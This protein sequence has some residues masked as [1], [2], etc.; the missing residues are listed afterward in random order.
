[1]LGVVLVRVSIPAQTSWPRSKLGRKGFI[2]LTLPHCFSSPKEVKT[3][4]LA[5]QKA[6]ADAEAMEGCFFPGLLPLACS[7]CFLIEPKNCQS[8][9]GPTHKGPSPLDHSLRKCPTAGSHGGTSPTEAPFSVITPACV[10][11][12]PQT[13]QYRCGLS[14]L[15]ESVWFMTCWGLWSYLWVCDRTAPGPGLLE[16]GNDV[17]SLASAF[18]HSRVCRCSLVLWVNLSWLYWLRYFSLR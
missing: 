9:D 16:Y 11:L 4:T 13:S 17:K 7:A 15:P 5:G 18:L 6:G 10:K 1:M 12:T 3:G 14:C 2:Q 8:R